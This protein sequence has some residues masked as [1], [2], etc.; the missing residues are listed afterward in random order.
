MECVSILLYGAKRKKTRKK[1]NKKKNK[2]KIKKLLLSPSDFK[3]G[4]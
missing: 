2:K 4:F 1:E 3:K